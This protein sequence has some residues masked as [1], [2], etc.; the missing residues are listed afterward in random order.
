[1]VEKEVTP[2]AAPTTNNNIS[3]PTPT[4]NIPKPEATPT[5]VTAPTAPAQNPA[6]KKRP[7]NYKYAGKET[8]SQIIGE[9]IPKQFTPTKRIG[10]IFGGVFLIV[11]VIAALQ[12][13]LSS[14]LS[15]NIDVTIKVGYPL[16][17]LE[18]ELKETDNSP[19]KPGSLILD[20]IIYMIV[21]YA[22][23]VI[24]SLILSNPLI[25]SKEE[26]KKIPII[27]KNRKPPVSETVTKKVAEK[28]GTK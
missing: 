23:D 7:I 4:S 27:F 25:K 1:M 5:T 21:A 16:T 11:L 6:T 28:T 10:G 3:N 19:I 14:F 20:L 24:L 12:F 18:L 15:G 26:N 22:I 9:S 8:L 2:A 17:F 13:P